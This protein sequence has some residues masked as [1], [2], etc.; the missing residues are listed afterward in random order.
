[1]SNQK[2]SP[3][4]PGDVD[5]TEF[6]EAMQGGDI[7]VPRDMM[8]MRGAA[9]SL[10]EEAARV[11]SPTPETPPVAPGG[12]DTKEALRDFLKAGQRLLEAME[13]EGSS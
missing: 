8:A 7:E 9:G 3:A 2:F 6:M 10:E 11:H 13:R 5:P 12:S 4:F 1:M